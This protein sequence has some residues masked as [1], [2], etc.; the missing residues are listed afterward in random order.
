MEL[1]AKEVFTSK[2]CALEMAT[3]IV[4][5][6]CS[7]PPFVPVADGHG[8]SKLLQWQDI[9]QAARVTV[10]ARYPTTRTP[11]GRSLP[12]TAS[13]RDPRT[14][15]HGERRKKKLALGNE[16]CRQRENEMIEVS[17]NRSS[18]LLTPVCSS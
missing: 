10:V 5:H 15:A 1:H 11:T 7:S 4:K 12:E 16:L 3:A 9:D 2:H 6:I 18:K 8:D 14:K 17:K 13:L